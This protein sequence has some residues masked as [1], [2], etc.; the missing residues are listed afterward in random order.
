MKTVFE[1]SLAVEAYMICDLLTRAGVPAQVLGEYLQ[2]A[3]GE[4]PVGALV[5]VTVPDEHEAEAREIIADWER[6]APPSTPSTAQQ[7]AAPR[8][9]APW[10]ALLGLVVGALATWAI[11]RMPATST[12][13][14]DGVDYDLDGILDERL[15]MRGSVVSRIESDR[16]SDRSIDSIQEFDEAGL[17]ARMRFDD[18]FDGRYESTYYLERGL[19]VRFELDSNGDDVVDKDCR[20]THGVATSCNFYLPGRATPV[21]RQAF[22]GGWLVSAEIDADGDGVFDR[23]ILYD[24]QEEPIEGAP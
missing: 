1:S 20:Y 11:Y 19:F 23:T 24:A 18:N 7:P 22:R 17:A 12:V 4:L 5:R 21:K 6:A 13:T 10:W 9:G 2:G 8:S 3:A 14:K 16:N 15:V